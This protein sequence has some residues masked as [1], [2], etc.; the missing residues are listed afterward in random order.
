VRHPGRTMMPPPPGG[1]EPS[2]GVVASAAHDLAMGLRAAY[3]AL[4]RRTNAEFA[5][6]G[7]TADQFVVLTAL[8][9]GDG[10][11][12]KE[13]VSRTGSDPNTMSEML[14]RLEKKGLVSRQ[15]HADDGRARSVTL[16]ARGRQIQATMWEESA[17]LRAALESLFTS[18]DL[19]ALA[20]ALGRI[21]EAMGPPM[22][23]PE[24]VPLPDVGRRRPPARNRT[25]GD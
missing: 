14:S 17:P 20:R 5:R 22:A 25:P 12:Q 13:L 10:V 15:R 4:H 11:T 3:L 19:D 16:S 9:E 6:L 23:D 8:A 21:A 1:P 7:L 2:R 24:A 18:Q